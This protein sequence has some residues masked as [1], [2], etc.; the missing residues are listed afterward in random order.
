MT[1]RPIMP[2]GHQKVPDSDKVMS[3]FEH[4]IPRRN[5][6]RLVESV[7]AWRISARDGRN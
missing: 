2:P 3:Y 4:K 1:G 5:A 7:H 6:L